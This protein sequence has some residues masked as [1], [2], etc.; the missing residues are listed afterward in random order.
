MHF[1]AY[2]PAQIQKYKIIFELCNFNKYIGRLLVI[3]LV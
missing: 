3:I 1:I 2:T